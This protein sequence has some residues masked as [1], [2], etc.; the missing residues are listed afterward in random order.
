MRVAGAEIIGIE[1]FDLTS[2][3]YGLTSSGL[4]L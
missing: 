2:R 1:R 3:Y 4:N